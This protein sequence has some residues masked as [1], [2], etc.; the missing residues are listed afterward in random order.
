MSGV[1][2]KVLLLEVH[3]TIRQV[4]SDH[5]GTVNVTEWLALAQSDVDP[6]EEETIQEEKQL[7]AVFEELDMDNDQLLTASELRPWE[8]GLYHT[9]QG[10]VE[11]CVAAEAD[12]DGQVT[13]EE[14]VE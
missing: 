9:K 5:D 11:L 8:S 13:P 14:L 7:R 4:D 12:Q 2:E 3:E 1:N 6:A 10:L